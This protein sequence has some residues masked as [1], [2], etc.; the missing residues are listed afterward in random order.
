MRASCGLF[1]QKGSPSIQA[2]RVIG[3]GELT[4]I[5]LGLCDDMDI[6]LRGLQVIRNSD[7]VFAEFY[8]SLMSGFCMER[9][10]RRI[11]KQVSVVCRKDLEEDKGELILQKAAE[12]RV[13]FLVPGD[14][15]IA[16][17]HVDLRIRARKRGIRT[18]IVHGAS[19][20]SAVTG[21]SGLQNY[22]FGRSV[23]IPFSDGEHISETPYDVIAKNRS[24][25]FHTLCFLDVKAEER[26]F[27]TVNEALNVLLLL[28]KK[29]REGVITTNSLAIGV[30]RAGC[31][32]VIVKAGYLE[33]LLDYDFGGPPHSLVIPADRLHFMEAEALNNL[34]D[35]AE[36]VRGMVG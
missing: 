33:D 28:E 20:I 9:F 30:A 17:T 31:E 26:R 24:M 21:L 7:F 29:R 8:T 12:A 18:K 13:A 23:T 22:R 25:N 36:K 16:T 10:K 5:G 1:P 11:G 15:L 34:A 14:P 19:I 3:M 32:D 2:D 27:M 4:F 35:A 6:S